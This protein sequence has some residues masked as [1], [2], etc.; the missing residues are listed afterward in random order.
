M[1]STGIPWFST[2]ALPQPADPIFLAGRA[3]GL[4]GQSISRENLA[5]GEFGAI[6]FWALEMP[7]T[8]YGVCVKITQLK[9]AA[10]FDRVAEFSTGSCAIWEWVETRFASARL[11]KRLAD[12]LISW[13]Q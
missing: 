7:V 1:Q 4:F 2:W 3:P 10:G 6:T 12:G 11:L 5:L 9:D 13:L 8:A